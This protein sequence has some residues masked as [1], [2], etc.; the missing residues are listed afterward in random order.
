MK[1]SDHSKLSSPASGHA[2]AGMTLVE[3]MITIAL[4]SLVIAGVLSAQFVGLREDQLMESK[5]GI[6]DKSR[7]A[8]SQMLYD[9]KSAKGY[10]IGNATSFATFTALTNGNTMQGSALML[11]TTVIS[12][13][14]A[15]NLTNYITT[16]YFDTN[17]VA[18]SDGILWRA[19][20]A[21]S[22]TVVASNLI[23]TFTF[24]SEN[25]T[26]QVQTVRTYKGVVHAILQFRQFQYPL[27]TVGTN[28]IFDYYRIDCRATPHLPDGP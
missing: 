6:S 18:N 14:Q 16:Y 5:A 1:F 21:N 3:V 8:I 2:R 28:G 11:Y 12:T 25:Y 20:S 22:A 9:I 23:N 24:S 4:L 15:I 10:L 27:T 19:T 13:N 7:Q 17:N 26:N